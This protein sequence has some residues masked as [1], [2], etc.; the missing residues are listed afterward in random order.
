MLLSFRLTPKIWSPKVRGS[1][2]LKQK[3]SKHFTL[4]TSINLTSMKAHCEV[5]TCFT[6]ML[7]KKI[8]NPKPTMLF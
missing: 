8:E 2:P 7:S 6:S 5:D 4:P 3:T 1:L